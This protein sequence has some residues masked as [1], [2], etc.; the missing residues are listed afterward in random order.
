MPKVKE[1][2]LRDVIIPGVK[3]A[4]SDVVRNSID[5]ILYGE[6][7]R[8]RKKTI[9]SKTSY[10]R[11]YEDNSYRQR[12]TS[13]SY[14]SAYDYDDISF[15][16]RGDA[17]FVLS[18]MEDI[19][20][21]YGFVKVADLYELVGKST[22]NHCANNYGWTDLRTAHVER[23]RDGYIIKLPKALPID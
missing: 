3:K 5:M 19:I 2:I 20:E 9:G 21:R 22:S 4:I 18:Q 14:R 12:E 11:Y 6:S 1:Y 17:E 16:N 7:E 23:I 15:Y 13:S 10:G 8:D